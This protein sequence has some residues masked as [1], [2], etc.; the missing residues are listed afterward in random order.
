MMSPN[1]RSFK[2]D[3]KS[4]SVSVMPLVL[5]KQNIELYAQKFDREQPSKDKTV[6]DELLAWFREHR[7]LNREMFL[8]LCLWKSPRAKK[9][10][11]NPINSDQRVTAITSLA[12]SSDDEYFKITVLQILPGVQ[13]PV[14]SVIL[15]FAE[16]EKYPILDFRAIWSLGL[17]KPKQYTFDFWQTYTQ[18]VNAI[19]KE[20]TV[21]LRILDKALW[22]YS[23]EHQSGKQ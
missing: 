13:W 17:N 2:T 8:K 20:N 22:Q 16:P 19:A 21:S 6:E 14:A 11:E 4:L 5:T 1:S 7:F 23:K 10:Y 18:K 12:L 15:H 9:H 3:R